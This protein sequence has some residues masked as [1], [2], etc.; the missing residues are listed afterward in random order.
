LSRLDCL[1][2]A[3]LIHKLGVISATDSQQVKAVWAGH[4]KPA[5]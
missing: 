5:F 4:V 3:L 1:E 2:Q